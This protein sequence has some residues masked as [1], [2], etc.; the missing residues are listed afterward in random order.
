M[1]EPE[2]VRA[3]LPQGLASGILG[4]LIVKLIFAA[5]LLVALLG[6]G[7]AAADHSS[8]IL[9]NN[10]S[11]ALYGLSACATL[12]S[13]FFLWRLLQVAWNVRYRRPVLCKVRLVS[14]TTKGLNRGT[15]VFLTELNEHARFGRTSFTWTP[16]A[17]LARDT[18]Y[19]YP[20]RY[21][22]IMSPGVPPLA[23]TLRM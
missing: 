13:Y 15:V 18:A 22:V 20:G 12:P 2:G 14:Q 6:L 21:P 11:P 4:S 1:N 9:R 16:L 8:S 5:V 3:G 23:S 19:V 10:I 17:F 7:G